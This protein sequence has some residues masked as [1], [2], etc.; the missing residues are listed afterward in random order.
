MTVARLTVDEEPGKVLELTVLSSWL[1][2][3]RGLLGTEADADPVVL[4]RCSSIHTYGMSYP[5]D[6]AFIGE[7]GEVLSVHESV[8]PA[9]CLSKTGAA[10]VLERP[11][12]DAPWVKAGQ[13]LWISAISAGF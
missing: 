4:T 9:R 5:I 12:A 7:R 13:H 1:S 8:G 2:R 10:C 11:T 3:L 6:V